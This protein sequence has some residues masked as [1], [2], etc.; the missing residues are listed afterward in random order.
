MSAFKP[1]CVDKKAVVNNCNENFRPPL[2]VRVSSSLTRC[3]R[4]ALLFALSEYL[5]KLTN[6][7]IK[8]D[9]ILI[10]K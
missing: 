5:F 1:N 6:F 2:S 4:N 3:S 9:I 7:K 8:S 10:D